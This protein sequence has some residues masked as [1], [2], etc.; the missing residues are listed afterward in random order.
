MPV[1]PAA[2]VTAFARRTAVGVFVAAAGTAVFVLALGSAMVVLGAR[3]AG[4]S[5]TPSPWWAFAA[6]P[7][8]AFATWRAWRERLPRDV[9]AGHLDRRL[10]AHGLLL[11]ACEAG[12]LSAE[13]QAQLDSRLQ[14]WREA[15]P[16]PPWRTLLR[17]GLAVAFAAIV[18]TW[19]DG[20]SR[21]GPRSPGAYAT[22]FANVE[23]Q[24][25][26]A[27]TSGLLS[28]ELLMQLGERL[29]KL[30][31]NVLPDDPAAW[32]ELDALGAQ[33]AREQLLASLD[34]ASPSNDR[35]GDA[36]RDAAVSTAMAAMRAFAADERVPAMARSLLE[37]AM[38]TIGEDVQRLMQD[39]ARM[40][41]LA[42]MA[43][44]LAA[45]FGEG[46]DRGGLAAGDLQKLMQA[47]TSLRR[48]ASESRDGESRGA[49]SAPRAAIDR[50]VQQ[51]GAAATGV[52]EA[53]RELVL[54]E[55]APVPTE[56]RPSG[57]IGASGAELPAA[58]IAGTA[59]RGSEPGDPANDSRTDAGSVANPAGGASWQ[60]RLAPHHRGVVQKF[61]ASGASDPR[62]PK[63][64][65]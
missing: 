52:G 22:G 30:A 31:A 51:L 11:A 53:L 65:R 29:A 17:P 56:W 6:L 41:E 35:A 64:R 3:L 48:E 1:T 34:P 60:L 59:S 62:G 21:T 39:P 38:G 50:I 44:D 61:F 49:A 10:G 57:A 46:G 7:M 33:L 5:P 8:L 18:V 28:P 42:G 58:P 15:L 27:A 20:R 25:A 54:P 37:S 36:G 19:P 55:G 24:L 16:A 13:W 23:K 47:A 45:R 26:S 14:P 63:E 43:S 9:A 12:P 32:R 40:R 2:A 4:S